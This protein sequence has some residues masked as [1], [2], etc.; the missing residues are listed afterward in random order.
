ML[1][2]RC[3]GVPYSW[4]YEVGNPTAGRHPSGWKVHSRERGAKSHLLERPLFA[5]CWTDLFLFWLTEHV[6]VVLVLH[7]SPLYDSRYHYAFSSCL[8]SLRPDLLLSLSTPV[9]GYRGFYAQERSGRDSRSRSRSRSRRSR[10]D[11]R[12]PSRHRR[13]RTPEDR[14]RG[15]RRGRDDSHSRSRSRS[16]ARHRYPPCWYMLYVQSCSRRAH[17]LSYALIFFGGRRFCCHTVESP[18]RQCWDLSNLVYGN[19][20]F[21]LVPWFFSK[22]RVWRLLF[23][24]IRENAALF[25]PLRPPAAVAGAGSLTE[26]CAICSMVPPANMLRR[27]MGV[28]PAWALAAFYYFLRRVNETDSE[29]ARRFFYLLDSVVPAFLLWT[30]SQV[31]W[32]G[33]LRSTRV[34]CAL[35]R[36]KRRNG[37]VF[38]ITERNKT[39]AKGVSGW[40]WSGL[41]PPLFFCLLSAKL[42]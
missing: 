28:L 7:H 5:P 6:G 35:K 17:G 8:W 30:K 39:W 16:P 11:S 19:T 29:Q 31:L 26:T 33:V 15:S 18:V 37:Y 23:V 2:L 10:G 38:S 36:R 4:G 3:G 14:G 9:P 42:R 13:S 12:S 22:F 27:T 40:Y 32:F 34:R 21:R 25:L 1:S 24:C 20:V 41:P